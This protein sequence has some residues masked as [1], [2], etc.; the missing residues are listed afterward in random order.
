LPEVPTTAEGGL[1]NSAYDFWVGVFL[2]AQTPRDIVVRLHEETNRALQVPS[3][4]ERLAVLGVEP[5]PMDLE[6]LDKY[7][8]DDVEA[9]VRLVKAANIVAQQ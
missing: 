3:V 8:R 1:P 9:N 2:P 6:H 7:F 4:Q 5:M